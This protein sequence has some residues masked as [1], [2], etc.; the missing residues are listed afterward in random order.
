MVTLL[1]LAASALAAGPAARP[2]IVGAASRSVRLSLVLPL[3]TD[4]AGLARL[5]TA[6]TTPGSPMYD[7]YQSIGSLVRRFGAPAPERARVLA[8]LRGAGATGVSIDRSGLF[9]DASMSVGQA[10][11]MFG[12]G[13]ADFRRGGATVARYVA[14][15]SAVRIPAALR[16]AVTGVVGLDTL[17]LTSPRPSSA[18][19]AASALPPGPGPAFDRRG[20]GPGVVPSGYRDRSGTPS[21]CPPALA[22]RGFTPSQYLNAY[23][24]GPLFSAGLTGGGEHVALIEINGYK[25]ADIAT[26]AACFGIPVPQISTHRFGL[27]HLAAPGGETTLDLEVLSGAA[28]GLSGIDV[29][30]SSPHASDVLRALTVPVTRPDP[31]AVISASLGDCERDTKLALGGKGI[32]TVEASLQMAAARGISVLASSGDAGS[33]ACLDEHGEPIPVKA[34]SFPASSPWVTGVGGTNF[35]LNQSNDILDQLVWNDPTGATG[36]GNSRLFSRPPWQKNFSRTAYR[37]VPDVSM[38]G[39]PAP[40]YQIYCSVRGECVNDESP[41]PWVAFGGTSAGAPLL[42]GGLADVD[43]AL[44]HLGRRSLGLANPVFYRIHRGPYRSAVFYDVTRFNNDYFELLT[45]GRVSLGCC[46]ARYGYDTASGL[47]TVNLSALATAAATVVPH[48]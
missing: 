9:A 36:G 46:D 48:G 23:G 47:G 29:Y 43:E 42:A 35:R 1:S 32:A 38:L 37:A 10:H 16:G 20:A 24:Y 31:P 8:Y 33:S 4:T 41:S 17:A 11:R 13:L 30:E 5:A 27:S 21:G 34:V 3:M 2:A 40:G 15:T 45:G 28:P 39:D 25:P 14:P 12:V 6:I 18:S 7:H 26:Y 19:W 44:A 22:G